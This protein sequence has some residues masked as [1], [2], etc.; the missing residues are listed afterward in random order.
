M[1]FSQRLWNQGQKEFRRALLGFDEREKALDLFMVQHGVLHSSALDEGLPYSY[2]DE[3]LSDL[4]EDKIRRIPA[5]CDHSIAW[6]LWHM[7]RIEDVTMN[8]LVADEPQL[9]LSDG[10]FERLKIT[11]RDT[12]NRMRAGDIKKLSISIDLDGLLDYR[13][14][15]GHRT[16]EVVSQLTV[17]DL[18]R[19]VDPQRLQKILDV[20]AVVEQAMDLIEYWGKRTIAGLLLMPPTRHNCVH[21]NESM[22]LRKRK[23]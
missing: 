9:F 19:K 14:A 1:E 13:L 10:W 7:A 23:N 4:N 5:N 21:L 15:V 18:K 17:G 8:M 6:N 11:A 3:I 2:Q 22:R 16:R 12:G 20:G